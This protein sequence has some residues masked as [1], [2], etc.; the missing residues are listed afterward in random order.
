MCG[1]VNKLAIANI[2]LGVM[3]SPMSAVF[4]SMDGIGKH[5][6]FMDTTIITASY[7]GVTS[8]VF[9]IAA[10]VLTIVTQDKHFLLLDLV[11][12]VVMGVC[13]TAIM[14]MNRIR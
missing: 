13:A 8:F 2:A 14:M 6:R 7:M 10:S 4:K 3:Y 11:P 9:P 12:P 1:V 5:G